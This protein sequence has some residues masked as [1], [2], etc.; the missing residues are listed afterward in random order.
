M[1]Q[2]AT[3]SV[4]SEKDQPRNLI[5]LSE[6]VNPY[7][8]SNDTYFLVDELIK[9]MKVGADHFT[10]DQKIS[11]IQPNDIDKLCVYTTDVL[12]YWVD[13][14]AQKCTYLSRNHCLLVKYLK[15]R[16]EATKEAMEYG[17]GETRHKKRKLEKDSVENSD[18]EDID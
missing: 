11:D 6:P 10:N 12:A 7:K 8:L 3:S 5:N 9:V 14:I 16:N 18:M 15:E 17:D 13:A 2:Q 4:Q 1:L